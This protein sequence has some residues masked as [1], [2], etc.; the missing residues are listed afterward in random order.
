[1]SEIS[2]LLQITA[3]NWEIFCG[4]WGKWEE[5]EMEGGLIEEALSED[6]DKGV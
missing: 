2:F 3:E 1:M 6:V 5:E 4:W